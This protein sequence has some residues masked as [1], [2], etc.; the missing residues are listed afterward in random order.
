MLKEERKECI[1]WLYKGQY[2]NKENEG[3]LHWLAWN[4]TLYILGQKATCR[5]LSIISFHLGFT[6]TQRQVYLKKKV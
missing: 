2:S 1:K 4:D 6:Y 5:T 3:G